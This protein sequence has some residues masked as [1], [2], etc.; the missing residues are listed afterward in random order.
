MT[1]TTALPHACSEDV[2]PIGL[3]ARELDRKLRAQ[4]ALIAESVETFG[5]LVRE[6][7]A[8]QIHTEL[9]YPSWPAYF[10]SLVGGVMPKL[11]IADRREI[12][13]VLA[14]T[15]LSDY[16]ISKALGIGH[17]TVARDL[18]F[19]P[20]AERR[21]TVGLDGKRYNAQ[22]IRGRK[23]MKPRA[24]RKAAKLQSAAQRLRQAIAEFLAAMDGCSPTIA[25]VLARQV[26][27]DANEALGAL[28]GFYE[29]VDHLPG[30]G[31]EL[32]GL[33]GKLTSRDWI[34][35]PRMAGA[36]HDALRL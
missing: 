35:G 20:A 22:K 25:K 1:T 34:R 31:L 2:L 5:A 13:A 36:T 9:G 11:R 12:V 24:D 3:S 21:D 18:T 28:E 23:P 26:L 27:G 17:T 6:A 7:K 14:G 10:V 8:R 33:R 32:V 19:R 30:S 4:V 16:A 29:F 15:G